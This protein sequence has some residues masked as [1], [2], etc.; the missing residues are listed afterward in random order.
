LAGTIVLLTILVFRVNVTKVGSAIAQFSTLT[1]ITNICLYVAAW[2]LATVKWHTLVRTAPLS[3]LLRLNFIGQYYSTLLPGQLA[4]EAV[5]AYRLGRGDAEAERLAASVIIDRITGLLALV[6]VA[7][8]GVIFTRT[9]VDRPVIWFLIILS[10]VLSGGIFSLNIGPW[11]RVLRSTAARL[12]RFRGRADRLLDA[13][14][15]YGTEPQLLL[16]A[17]ALGICFQLSAIAMNMIFARELGVTLAFADWCWLFGI[18][19]LVS[20]LPLTIGGLGLREGSFVGTLGLVGVAPEKAL[21]ISLG[22]FG[23]ILMGA[24]IGGV[25][26]F[27]GRGAPKRP[28]DR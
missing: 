16:F 23:L 21:A 1:W 25:F 8:V 26:E 13:W 18:V 7:L 14:R 27:S 24:A 2:T 28:K 22:V 12:G 6:I 17:V 11:L 15:A 4:G 19:S 3:L 20:M 10:F 5:K 9:Y